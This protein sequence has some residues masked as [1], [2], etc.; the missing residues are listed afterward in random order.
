MMPRQSNGRGRVQPIQHL[1]QAQ[2]KYVF[3]MHISSAPVA[4]QPLK[5]KGSAQH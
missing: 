5:K 3:D 1:R 2:V 4:R